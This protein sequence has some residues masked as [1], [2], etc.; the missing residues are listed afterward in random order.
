MNR[1]SI[2]LIAMIIGVLA[3]CKEENVLTVNPRVITPGAALSFTSWRDIGPPAYQ[4]GVTDIAIQPSDSVRMFTK[5]SL[6]WWNNS[7]CFEPVLVQ[8]IFPD[9]NPRPGESF[10]TT[11][12]LEYN[13]F[14]RGVYNFSPNLQQTLR[15]RPNANWAGMQERF[16]WEPV[17]IVKLGSRY[18]DIWMNVDSV[19]SNSSGTLYIDL[20]TF[21]EDVIPN[22]HLNSEDFIPTP[23]N[24]AGIPTGVI[25]LGQDLGLDMLSDDSERVVYATFLQQNLNDPDVDPSDPSGDDWDFEACNP[26]IIHANGT[27]ANR[28]NRL[29]HQSPN[30][31]FPDTED[32]NNNGG[33]DR[34]NDYFEYEVPLGSAT[35]D[36]HRVLVGPNGWTHYRISFSDFVRRIGTPDLFK[37]QGIRLWLTGFTHRVKIRFASLSFAG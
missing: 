30:G 8:E 7:T 35:S 14:V 27:E 32:L 1:I 3:G 33:M 18:I 22:G 15:E 24:P 13:P 20:G 2:S 4:E 34:D 25:H 37:L 26:D 12:N 11:L 29:G 6:H 5:A 17:D 10:I 28:Q 36:P 23:D 21:S 9:S 19:D 16:L 31:G